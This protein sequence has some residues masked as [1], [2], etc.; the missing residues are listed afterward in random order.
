MVAKGSLKWVEENSG[1]IYAIL[2]VFAVVA[3]SLMLYAARHLSL[4]NNA[5]IRDIQEERE[6]ATRFTCEDINARHR[7]TLKVLDDRI[8]RLI[9]TNPERAAQVKESREFTVLLIEAIVP[10]RNCEEFTKKFVDSEVGEVG[11]EGK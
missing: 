3:M 8:K 11:K 5:R 9:R 2:L 4:E 6:F 7:R 1:I 10:L